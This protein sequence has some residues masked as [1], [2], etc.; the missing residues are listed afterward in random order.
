MRATAFRS[1][2]RLIDVVAFLVSPFNYLYC[3]ADRV[4]CC[5]TFL[6]EAWEVTAPFFTHYFSAIRRF[7]VFFF[8]S[9]SILLN[10]EEII[11]EY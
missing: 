1:S 3:D 11:I 8:F 10:K 6:P 5:A 4:W 9:L 7:S 2:Q